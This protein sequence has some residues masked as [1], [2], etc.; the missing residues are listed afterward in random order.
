MKQ[1][2]ISYFLILALLLMASTAT[3]ADHCVILQYHH[4]SNDTPAITSVTPEQFEEQLNYLETNNFHILPLREVVR[5]LKS[6]IELPERCVALTV[7]D[8]WLSVYESAF[9]KL[10]KR[11][12]PMTVFVNSE[13]IDKQ[14]RN[15]LSWHQ[16]R[17][18]A[19]HG[20]SFE[21]HGHSHD[22]LIRK[23]EQESREQWLQRVRDNVVKANERIS[24]ELGIRPELFAYPYGEY[25]PEVQQIV[26]SL[27]LTG[28]GQ[29]SGPVSRYS[30][31]SALPRFPIA[32]SYAKLPGFITKVNTRALPVVSVSP[33]NPVLPQN[34]K[35]P[36][37]TLKLDIEKNQRA[38]LNCFVNGSSEVSVD[39]IDETTVQVKPE[40]DLPA[41][42]SRT[43]CTMPSGLK[44]S[45]HWYSHNWIK[46][47]A[48]GSWYQEY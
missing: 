22:H 21:N 19:Q 43:N 38:R 9:P 34:M 46:K 42:R 24:K 35:R 25:T 40:F 30:D 41:G 18:M 33:A 31:F 32:G 8:A 17:E 36:Q 15:T 47:K 44:G 6:N 7:D 37:L 13:N 26:S 11:G 5:K 27:D 10:K 23:G 39:W 28:F 14:Q 3:A 12:W 1:L 2:T 16:M 29:Q 48:D 45:F 4:F 20:F